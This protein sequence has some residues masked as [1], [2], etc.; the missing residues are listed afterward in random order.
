MVKNFRLPERVT[1][2]Y[3]VAASSKIWDS[4]S[5]VLVVKHRSY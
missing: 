4:Q 3:V 1:E 5:V 2:H